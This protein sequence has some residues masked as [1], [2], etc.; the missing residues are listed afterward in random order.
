MTDCQWPKSTIAS[1]EP[2]LFF[3]FFGGEAGF[4]ANPIAYYVHVSSV[5]MHGHLCIL[6][7]YPNDIAS[8]S[9]IRYKDIED[10]IN[11]GLNGYKISQIASE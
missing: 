1:L 5:H 10:E 7:V 11:S 3:S 2:R 6:S 4:E 9:E 8:K